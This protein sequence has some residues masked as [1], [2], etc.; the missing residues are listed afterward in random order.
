MDKSH[1]TT[2]FSKS[3]DDVTTQQPVSETKTFSDLVFD[4]VFDTNVKFEDGVRNV[5]V[6][7]AETCSKFAHTRSVPEGYVSYVASDDIVHVFH[8]GG[9]TDEKDVVETFWRGEEQ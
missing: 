7:D 2:R 1:V 4:T 3:V 5:K 9:K 6:S 8:L